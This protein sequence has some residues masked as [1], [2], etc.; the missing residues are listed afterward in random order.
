MVPIMVSSIG[1]ETCVFL[2][3]S[4]NKLRGVNWNT[5]LW[6][7]RGMFQNMTHHPRITDSSRIRKKGV[8]DTDSAPSFCLVCSKV[9]ADKSIEVMMQC[10][11][12]E[13]VML[14]STGLVLA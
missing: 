11:A 9:I 6:H 7:L 14:G 8:G 5:M 4:F 3:L 12:K 10:I 1:I 2:F 13:S